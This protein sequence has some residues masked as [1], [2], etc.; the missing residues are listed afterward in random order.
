M[1]LC[2]RVQ[3]YP[4]AAERSWVT[5]RAQLRKQWK[6]QPG[7]ELFLLDPCEG[8][9]VWQALYTQQWEKK[10]K[11]HHVRFFCGL[12]KSNESQSKTARHL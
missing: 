12:Q 7:K 11:N 5:N 1:V 6:I 8:L 4:L 3:W 9:Q 2:A 10:R